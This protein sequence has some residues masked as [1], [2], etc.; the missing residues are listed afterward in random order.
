MV[1]VGLFLHLFSNIYFHSMVSSAALVSSLVVT[2]IFFGVAILL[3]CL[4]RKYRL[5][6]RTQSRFWRFIFNYVYV[7]L[8]D[9]GDSEEGIE[10]YPQ[11]ELLEKDYT[12]HNPVTRKLAHIESLERQIER[13]P[14]KKEELQRELESVRALNFTDYVIRSEQGEE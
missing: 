3:W 5:D 10:E 11:E 8:E 1:L 9:K 7:N 14:E 6:K 12:F 2:L 13:H 4:I